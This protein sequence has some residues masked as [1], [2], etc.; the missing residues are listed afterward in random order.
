MR[1]ACLIPVA[2][3]TAALAAG[4]ARHKGNPGEWI[5]NV[6]V[7]HHRADENLAAGQTQVARASLLR[8]LEKKPPTSLGADDVRVVLQD[9]YFR[10]SEIELTEGRAEQALQFT[11]QGLGLGDQADLF[12][13]NLHIHRGRALEGLGRGAEAAKAYSRALR[14]NEQLLEG[15]LGQAPGAPREGP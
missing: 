3:L 13:A 15:V 6:A 10:L 9:T 1:G 12:S 2:L 4:C 8:V 7:A 14:I 11:E 5:D